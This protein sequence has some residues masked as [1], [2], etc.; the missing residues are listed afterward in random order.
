[1]IH[2]VRETSSKDFALSLV[3]CHGYLSSVHLGWKV[4]PFHI[5]VGN[6]SRV[7][8][9]LPRSFQYT[10]LNKISIDTYFLEIGQAEYAA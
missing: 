9:R 5:G 3:L 8:M 4:E 6:R 7:P 2:E 1:M 10:E